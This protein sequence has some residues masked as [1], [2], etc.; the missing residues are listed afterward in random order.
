MNVYDFDGTL[1]RGDSSVDFFFFCM[2]RKPSLLRF[3]PRLLLASLRYGAR[4]IDKSAYKEVFF[5]FLA[6]MD[7]YAS[8]VD[9]FWRSHSARLESWYHPGNG[10]VVVSASPD[11]LL[12]PACRMLGIKGL[13]ATRVDPHSGRITGV[14]CR[15]A[16]KVRRF[17]EQYP[18]AHIER[19]YS[20][21]RSDAPMARLADEAFIIRNGKPQPW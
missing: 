19:F 3:I 7:D 2:R 11:F 12:E 16:E 20:D 8:A 10:D 9:S 1:Y 4:R 15:G 18:D 14:N 5:A 17:R 21:S 13:I 6:G